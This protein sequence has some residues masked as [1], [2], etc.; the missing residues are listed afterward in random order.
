MAHT[1]QHA[2]AQ[3]PT[4]IAYKKEGWVPAILTII[5]SI[6]IPATA[7]YIHT[8]TYR[9]PRDVM[10]RQVGFEADHAPAAGAAAGH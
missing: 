1:T 3:R 10:M 2:P 6:V 7:Y 8:Q 5:A 4:S 9:D